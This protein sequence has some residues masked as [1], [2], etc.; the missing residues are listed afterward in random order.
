MR[1]VPILMAVALSVACGSGNSASNSQADARF[2]GTWTQREVVNGYSFVLTFE[3]RDDKIT[4][5]GTYAVQGGSSG[6]LRLT[7]DGSAQIIKVSMTFDSGELA[8]LN[9]QL[10]SAAEISGRVHLGPPGTLTPD[11]PVTFVKK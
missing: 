5:T 6:T 9:G 7:G 10:V 2:T 4:G 11:M 3:V 1:V 8:Q